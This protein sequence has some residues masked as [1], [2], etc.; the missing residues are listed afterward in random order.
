MK[1]DHEAAN[2]ASSKDREAE[3]VEKT[4][5]ALRLKELEEQIEHLRKESEALQKDRD[6]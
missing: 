3:A 4:T 2:D 5:T 6:E 1:A